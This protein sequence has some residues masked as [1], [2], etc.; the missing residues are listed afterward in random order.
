[1]RGDYQDRSGVHR[2]IDTDLRREL[3]TA[4][5]WIHVTDFARLRDTLHAID[6]SFRRKDPDWVGAG[7]PGC[8]HAPRGRGLQNTWQ[9]TR[10]YFVAGRFFR[11]RER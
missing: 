2:A 3:L 7:Q 5:A 10:Q 4:I 9:K 1:M 8:L 6:V 11:A